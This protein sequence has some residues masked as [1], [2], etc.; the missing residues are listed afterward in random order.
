MLE[1]VFLKVCHAHD[2]LKSYFLVRKI[3]TTIQ[4]KTC[5]ELQ[6]SKLTCIL[7]YHIV[8]EI[9]TF[10]QIFSYAVCLRFI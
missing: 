1:V 9:R 2:L 4:Q 7:E 5:E 6:T 3:R 8:Y 10:I